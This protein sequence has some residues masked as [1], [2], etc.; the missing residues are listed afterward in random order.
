MASK[1]EAK[2]RFTAET[3]DFQDSLKDAK[4]EIKTLNSELK[5]NAAEMRNTG[6][7]AE[8]LEKRHELLTQKLEANAQE[9]EA[10]SGKIEAATE[11]YGEDS[12]EV[13]KL[14]RQ[15]TGAQTAQQNIEAEI[16]GVNDRLD[17]Q[18]QA[19]ADNESALGQ[20][21]S[22]IE[23]QQSQLQDLQEEYINT[24][25]EFGTDSDEAEELAEKIRSLSD[26]LGENQ[27]TLEE[28]TTAAEN[29]G[30]GMEQAEG[31]VEDTSGALGDVAG[32]AGQAGGQLTSMISNV[33]GAIAAG[34]VAG[35]I[36]AIASAL[37][38]VGKEVVDTAIEFEES[39]ATIVQGTGL[40][41]DKLEELTD[42]ANEAWQAIANADME[43]G[44]YASTAAELNT[45]LGITGELAQAA[46]ED[47][48]R[49]SA[50]TGETATKS[51]DLFADAMARWNLEVT[52][53]PT[54]MDQ[55]TV[56][57]Q[58]CDAG[59]TSL[60]DSLTQYSTTWQTLGYSTEEA[61][62]QLVAW[63]QA[64]LSSEQMIRGLK[65]ANEELA[66][67]NIDDIP[68]ALQAT[69]DAVASADGLYAGLQVTIGDTGKTVQDVFGAK[70][71]GAWVSALQSGKVAADDYTA[72]IKNSD[73]AMM[74]TFE[75]S[76]TAKD[77]WSQQMAQLK[78][79]AADLF[80]QVGDGYSAYG[81]SLAEAQ[82]LNLEA[83][84][85]AKNYSSSLQMLTGDVNANASAI[86]GMAAGT[87]QATGEM[88]ASMGV[89]GTNFHNDI[90]SMENSTKGL[91]MEGIADGMKQAQ[92][93][94]QIGI[95][96]MQGA[97][98]NMAWKVPAPLLP[99]FAIS[100]DFDLKSKSVP[101]VYIAG[102]HA[103]GG[104]FD[105]PTLLTSQG[106]FLHGV[107][108]AGP[109]AIAPIETLQQYVI[110]AVSGLVPEIDYDLMGR[111]VAAA[112]AKMNI[113]MDV[114]GREFGRIVRSAI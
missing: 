63:E 25:L 24:A 111:R 2:I 108:E 99:E 10:L 105:Q 8:L 59:V 100:G 64:G 45:R 5:L 104:I 61:L 82:G 93:H 110:D 107:G 102:W 28:V 81:R 44:D 4:N 83:I 21:T 3:K 62:G 73:Q 86:S 95:T 101:T 9:Q 13:A 94:V 70:N 11:I 87:S 48:A 77:E 112:C 20:L 96:S 90:T 38:E 18:A 91:K 12:E 75:N 37:I 58:S 32:L 15:L 109:E 27:K 35:G 41:G 14:E 106:G 85:G 92:N 55:V 40:I 72:S 7:S 6:E 22:T 43:Q 103:K 113:S 60:M 34:G 51:V 26:D 69:M 19:A 16:S 66:K 47:F 97:M 42:A 89:L 84:A 65:K 54:L 79:G 36:M 67:T 74:T 88:S 50:I 78:T 53:I 76:R 114:D 23:E 46:T 17:E 98:A 31:E 52:D 71:A 33:A 1:N 39:S 80:K 56:A 49:F 30:S 68:G 29:L 57:N